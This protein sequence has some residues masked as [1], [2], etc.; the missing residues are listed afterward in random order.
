MTTNTKK[1]SI[2]GPTASFS[3]FLACKQTVKE[4]APHQL[5]QNDIAATMMSL[6]KTVALSGLD[7]AKHG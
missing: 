5:Y 1:A 2:K 6:S 4:G 7:V 3:F